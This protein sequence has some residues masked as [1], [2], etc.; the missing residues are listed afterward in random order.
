[1]QQS[2]HLYIRQHANNW[3]T[4]SVLTHPEY[5]CFG[6]SLAP[7]RAE[8]TEVLAQELATGALK[9]RGETFFEEMER[10][11]LELELRAVQHDRLIRVPMRFSM[12]VRHL[13]DTHEDLYEV[14]L[15]RLG[16][17]FKIYGAENIKP[18]GEEVVR[19]HFHLS[20]VEELLR[21]QYERGERIERL[22]VTWHGR[23][24]QRRSRGSASHQRQDP[25][26]ERRMGT[27]LAEVGVELTHEARQGRLPRAY[28]RGDELRQL[29]GILDSAQKRST[30]LVGASGV[31]KSALV[32]EV[33]HRIALGQVP[34]R[35]QEVPLW[36][37][38]GGRIIAGMK[39]LGQWQERCQSIVEEIRNERGILYVDSLLELMMSGSSRSGMSVASFLLPYVQ[40]G[41]ITVLAESTPDALL[42]AEQQG[43]N[44]VHALRRL[45]VA[46]FSTERSY[47][48][49]QK[50]TGRL[51]KEHKVSFTPEALSRALDVLARFG[52]ADALPGSG[53]KLIDQMARLPQARAV[54]AAA[55]GQAPRRPHGRP[56]LS[57][58]DAVAAFARSSGFPQDLIDPDC[59]LDV[60]SVR[61]FFT[62]RVIGQPD[63]TELL[64]NLI[65]VI[66]SSLNDPERPLGSFLFMGP[67]GVGK[68]ESA[69]TLSEY[70]FGDRDRLA[71]FDMSEYGYP[72]SASRLVGGSRGEGDLT[73][74]VREQPFSVLLFDEVEK[75]DPEVF[76]ILLQVLGEGRLTDGT[77]RTVRFT[78]A[79]IIMTS[80]LGAG[81]QKSIGMRGAA[82]DRETTLAHHYREAARAFF[83][84]EFINRVDF[85]V[86]FADLDAQAVRGI[87]GRMLDK[88][89]AREGFAR[90]GI[91]VQY[92]DE[93][94][95][96]LMEHG[97]D[98][99]YGA[100]PMKRAVEQRILIPL[101]RRLVLRAEQLEEQFQLYVD[102]GRVAV[103]S[104]RGVRGAP[105]PPVS[106][107]ALAHDHLWARYLRQI[108]VRLQDWEESA[109]LRTLRDADQRALPQRLRRASDQVTDLEA[110]AGATPSL[111]PPD[112]RA[113]LAQRAEALDVELD[114]LEW[115]LCLAA[116]PE[117][118]HIALEVEVPSLLPEALRA[119]RELVQ[120]WKTWAAGRG[121]HLEETRQGE[122]WRL[123][124]R[125]PGA[126]PLL[127]GE[128]G[129]HRL[130][131]E[132]E[133][134][135]EVLVR[136]AHTGAQ[137]RGVVREVSFD[138]DT[139][140]DPTTEVEISAS[141]KELAQHLDTLLLARLC[142]RVERLS[143]A[144]QPTPGT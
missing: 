77:G 7:L 6:P 32:H 97:F 141:L 129:V 17:R 79:I 2:F 53:L 65:M 12:L 4:A 71:R 135:R 43:A 61:D 78:H 54:E 26:M 52:D 114:A 33:A 35:I 127:C 94:L 20:D 1:M 10:R 103:V 74:R 34:L 87:A 81:N 76:D 58:V 70:L 66:K 118:D 104:S 37:V 55:R 106:G 27:P 100:R 99:R 91:T 144:A 69:L 95:D 28:D 133:T 18:W 45:P 89:L 139:L 16:Q 138:P 46:P 57:P 36:H 63:A 80:N 8:I 41:E 90:R 11:V 115:D 51:E 15:P 116:L 132:E 50:A 119:A 13:K 125:G 108:R 112:E 137:E 88:A 126:Y 142:A 72:G 44:F 131:L 107:L 143:R 22:D 47:Q 67:T 25:D 24:G 92:E 140:W 29:L 85:L 68:T 105:A 42:L 59:L 40:S 73:R 98:P 84:P 48:I 82:P 38:S 14:W 122:L 56:Q 49:L 23:G 110:A 5:A 75:A 120:G 124:I 117:G 3:L 121:L 21:Y 64:T 96:L 31:G 30:L 93:L 62:T 83:R 136:D 19:G 60:A 9:N 109:L 113:A 39:Y 123:D 128:V 101:S 111:L 86:P 130:L 134:Q 102:H